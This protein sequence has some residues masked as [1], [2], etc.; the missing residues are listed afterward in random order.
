MDLT[1]IVTGLIGAGL[2][3]FL[4]ALFTIPKT[5]RQLD[6]ITVK[7]YAEAREKD[8]AVLHGMVD[9]LQDETR[10]LNEQLVAAEGRVRGLL[11][12]IDTERRLSEE[13]VAGLQ[14]DLAARDLEI[15]RLRPA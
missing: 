10:R 1:G 11:D 3:S 14:R 15:T 12:Q 2:G 7:T 9:Q 6:A 4:V 5:R 8:A 13:R